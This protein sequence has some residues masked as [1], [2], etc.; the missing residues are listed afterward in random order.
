MGWWY[1]GS[2]DE[3]SRQGDCEPVDTKKRSIIKTITW[4]VTGST[5]TFLISYAVSG[6]FAAAGTIATIQL[7]SNTILYY[8]HERAWNQVRSV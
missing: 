2:G 7:I 3:L 5:A 4:R 6:S 8:M 1:E